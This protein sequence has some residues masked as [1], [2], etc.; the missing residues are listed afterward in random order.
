[1]LDNK[2]LCIIYFLVQLLLDIISY[3]KAY[4]V[5]G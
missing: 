2:T 3:I 4:L 5:E 1:M